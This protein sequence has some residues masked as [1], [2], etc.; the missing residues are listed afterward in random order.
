MAGHRPDTR[1]NRA[2][3]HSVHIGPEF[4]DK[5]GTPA[6]KIVDTSLAHFASNVDDRFSPKGPT[7]TVE[8][9]WGAISG[10]VPGNRTDDRKA[11]GNG[12]GGGPTTMS[13]RGG[14]CAS[15]R[16]AGSF[17]RFA[18]PGSTSSD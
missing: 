2:S 16:I 11:A 6:R 1:L 18:V 5:F 13:N 15:R 8:P 9:D 10:T 4:V 7:F 12:S 17:G 3:P 14:R